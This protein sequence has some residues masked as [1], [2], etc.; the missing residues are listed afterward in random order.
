MRY[1]AAT[2]TPNSLPDDPFEH[3]RNGK[4][5]SLRE[6]L[7]LD[8]NPNATDSKKNSL[9]MLST[10]H[11]HH[12]TANMLLENGAQVD[13]PNKKGQTPLEG[14]AFKEYLDV[15]ELLVESGA[16]LNANNGFR[17][18]PFSIAKMCGNAEVASY[19]ESQGGQRAA[20]S[21]TAKKSR[22]SPS[23][24]GQCLCARQIGSSTAPHPR[25]S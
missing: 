9:L 5:N 15:A 20:T 1:D 4:T 13:R 17:L 7:S 12:E 2:N 23:I 8:L 11:G 18:E 24:P 22:S 3:A 25:T 6:Q 10:Y 14:V 19:L 16:E 21:M